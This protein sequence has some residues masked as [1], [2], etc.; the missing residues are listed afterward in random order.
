MHKE[1]FDAAKKYKEKEDELLK[2]YDG[3]ERKPIKMA[4]TGDED[5]LNTLTELRKIGFTREHRIYDFEK[6][7]YHP[8]SH[9]FRESVRD[10]RKLNDANDLKDWEKDMDKIEKKRNKE[11]AKFYKKREEISRD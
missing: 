10:I 11:F 9:A 3:K 1:R 4:K 8:L 6:S 7:I 5:A 2:D